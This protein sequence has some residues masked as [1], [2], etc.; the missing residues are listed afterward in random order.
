VDAELLVMTAT[1]YELVLDKL[2]VTSRNGVKASARCPAHDDHTASLSVTEGDAGKVVVHCHAGCPIDE[3]VAAIGLNLGDLFPPSTNGHTERRIVA[4]YNYLNADSELAYQVVRYQPKDFRQ[5]RPDGRGGWIWRLDDTPRILYNLPQL[6]TQTGTVFVTEGEKDA[7]ALTAAG[8]LATCGA[9]GAGTWNRI[10]NHASEILAG[11]DV[12]V[13]A[14]R[15]PVGYKHARDVAHHLHNTA[16]SVTVVEAATGK[17]AA[18]HLAAG[19]TVDDLLII[20]DEPHN[21]DPDPNSGDEPAAGLHIVDWTELFAGITHEDPI[22]E[23]VAYRGRWTSYVAPGKAGKSTYTLNIAVA[24][25]TGLEP[26]D[27]TPCPPVDVLYLDA[28]MGRVDIHER[29]DD[30]NLTPQDLGNLYYTD[31]V[32]KLDTVEGSTRL[33]HDVQ[34]YGIGLVIIDGVNGA[35]GGAENDDTTWRAFYDLTIAPLKRAGI[36]VITNDNLGKDK[37]LGPRGSSVKID[38]PDA[39]IQLARTDD[40]IKLTC[41]HRRTAAYPLETVYTIHG[42]DGETPITFQRSNFS[43]PAGTKAKADELDDLAVPV[44]V[45]N[46]DARTALKDAGHPVGRNDVLAAA[47]RWRKLP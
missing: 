8:Y 28:E 14:D 29:L 18:D 44:H 45:S 16:A 10:A 15:D 11:R 25:Q 20:G 4:T 46:R 21:P 1:P 2:D 33:L 27:R 39:V 47:I 38:K 24:I 30:L 34:R 9:G 35:V 13:I 23:G 12:I 40:G 37:T 26:F 17:D 32:P 7:D 41:T 36:A 5:R 42:A 6:A 43:W 22:I 19:L 3:I 31:L